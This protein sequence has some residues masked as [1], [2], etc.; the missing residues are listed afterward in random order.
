MA[1]QQCLGVGFSVA[2]GLPSRRRPAATLR[3]TPVTCWETTSRASST[4]AATAAWLGTRLQKL[5]VPRFE[6]VDHGRLGMRNGRPA[7]EAMIASQ[8]ERGSAGDVRWR[9]AAERPAV[10]SAQVGVGVVGVMRS[11]R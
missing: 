3:T 10:C 2:D 7:A 1:G 6:Q 11:V 5:R 4:V 8:T 9:V